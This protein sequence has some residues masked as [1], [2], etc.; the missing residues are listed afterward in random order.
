MK[1]N[2][3]IEGLVLRENLVRLAHI[4]LTGRIPSM[5]E[6]PPNSRVILEIGE[7]DLLDLNFNARFVAEADTIA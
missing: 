7:I 5:P 3:I 1:S 2:L 6:L 4:P